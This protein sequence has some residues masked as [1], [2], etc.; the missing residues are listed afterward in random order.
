V[1]GLSRAKVSS[2]G[3]DYSEDFSGHEEF[4][5]LIWENIFGTGKVFMISIYA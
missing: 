3:P 4:S 5:M 2:P 1:G